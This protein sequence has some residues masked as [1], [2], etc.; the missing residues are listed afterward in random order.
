MRTKLLIILSLVI[1]VAAVFGQVLGFEFVDWD[2]T[3]KIVDNPYVRNGLTVEG[4]IWAFTSTEH[5]HHW[6]PI[7]WLSLMLDG[8]LFGLNPAGFHLTNLMLHGLNT[9]LLLVLLARVIQNIWPAALVAAL[10]ALHPMHVEPVAWVT[11]RAYL[12]STLWM[13]LA[14]ETYITYTRR[15]S[16]GPYLLMAGLVTL[17]MV[18]KPMLVT[19]PVLLLLFDYWPL[20]RIAPQP[21]RDHQ[22]VSLLHAVLEKLPLWLIAAL[23]SFTTWLVQRSSPQAA[24]MLPITL[25]QRLANAAV[26]YLRYLAAMF[27]PADLGPL[28]PHPNLPGGAA[29]LPRDVATAVILL[30]LITVVVVIFG[31]RRYLLV[32]WLWFLVSLGPV[33]GLIQVGEQ[34][35]ADR[36]SYV[37]LIGIF[38][39]LS[40]GVAELM[41]VWSARHRWVRP[42]AAAGLLLA[43][44]SIVAWN[45]TGY[46]HDS[47]T[48]FT[49]ACRVA[50]TAP[51]A[52]NN[53]G[54]ALRIKGNLDLAMV[55]YRVALK[56]RPDYPEAHYNLGNAL[57]EK[58]KFVE[59]MRHS[60]RA[61]QLKSDYAQAHNNLA[62]ALHKLGRLAE[63]THH[64]RRAIEI[65]S[66]FAV[67]HYNLANLFAS[68]GRVDE[69]IKH[70]G[71]AVQINPGF[72]EAQADLQLALQIKAARGESD[73]VQ[74]P[75]QAPPR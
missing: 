3:Y 33:I 66:N 14:I 58:D 70:L 27:W 16:L 19:L 20:N 63:A 7:T 31:R 57:Y 18:T 51:T 62:L 8:Q 25:T 60:L 50:P 47:V 22:H 29:W 54:Y 9:L 10:F 30:I 21:H 36:Y 46:W 32:G 61:V 38:F 4:F 74:D 59:S 17:A 65:N 42:A 13:L 28:Y 34:A 43:A 2:D 64:F 41:A 12:L 69:V 26:S 1:T 68:Q 73:R 35:M 5:A 45:Q 53:L 24:A 55:H 72:T 67:A 23:F 52:H 44:L 48:L 37:P 11:G 71:R 6:N 56:Y 40:G 75:T 39:M 15:R 49:R